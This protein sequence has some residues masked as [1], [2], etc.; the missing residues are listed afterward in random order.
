MLQAAYIE[1]TTTEQHGQ[2]YQGK[3]QVRRADRLRAFPL[4]I[5]EPN[6]DYDTNW[7][8][9]HGGTRPI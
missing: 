6:L 4:L 8:V 9:L 2:D 1:Q 7:V 3:G 5:S